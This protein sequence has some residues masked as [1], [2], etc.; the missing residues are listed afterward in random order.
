MTTLASRL[1]CVYIQ[2]VSPG[3]NTMNNQICEQRPRKAQREKRDGWSGVV[4]NTHI[5]KKKKNRIHKELNMNM[6]QSACL[7]RLCSSWCT[8]CLACPLNRGSTRDI[9]KNGGL[10]QTPGRQSWSALN[11]DQISRLTTAL[12]QVLFLSA[13]Q[14]A[15]SELVEHLIIP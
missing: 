5:A 8:F 3:L 15:G 6:L 7:L 12:N 13:N 2:S 4:N 10:S 9:M 11:P 14:Y 1:L